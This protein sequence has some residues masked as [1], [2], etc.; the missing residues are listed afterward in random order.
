MY[1][2]PYFREDDQRVLHDFMRHY[3]FAALVTLDGKQFRATHLPFLLDSD[4]G[5]H[6][7]LIAHMARA[8]Q[9]WKTFDG[10]QE[11]L[12]IFQGPHAYVTPSWYDSAPSNVPTWN[13]TV[14]HAY[15]VPRIIEDHD[16]VYALLNRLVNDNET[17]FETPWQMQ[18][19]EAYVHRQ[20][21]AIVAF[22][23]P[24]ARLEGKYK[25]SQNRNEADRQRVA[26]E[27]SQSDNT[28]DREVGALMKARAE[29]KL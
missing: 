21:A 22:E 9:Q 25:L 15:G 11:A 28:V 18:S 12:I 13:M 7:T 19:S 16:Q 4:R 27:L 8:N 20:I 2:P 26:E 5:P 6:G 10:E 1:I 17:P 29:K 3:N 24:I 23:I 14:V